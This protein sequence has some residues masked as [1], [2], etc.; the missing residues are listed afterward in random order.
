MDSA[1]CPTVND[2]DLIEMFKPTISNNVFIIIYYNVF[3]RYR[4]FKHVNNYDPSTVAPSF[5]R[6]FRP[7]RKH[8][9]QIHEPI[10]RDGVRGVQANSFHYRIPTVWNNLP[11]NVVNASSLDSFNKKLYKLWENQPMKY[12]HRA[13]LQIQIDL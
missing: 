9:F 10:P 5:Q 11:N 13:T 1:I 4:W 3:I 7:S 12:D 2:G 6:R 8:E